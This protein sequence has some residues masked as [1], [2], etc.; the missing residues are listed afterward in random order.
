MKLSYNAVSCLCVL[1]TKMKWMSFEKLLYKHR[2]KAWGKELFNVLTSIIVFFL[3]VVVF[4]IYLKIGYGI[5]GREPGS[6]GILLVA[7]GSVEGL[8]DGAQIEGTDSRGRYTV[9]KGHN[10]SQI[11]G[12]L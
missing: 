5:W 10:H 9:P 1:H 3:S 7:K 12:I 2:S 4:V 8:G 11:A 6:A